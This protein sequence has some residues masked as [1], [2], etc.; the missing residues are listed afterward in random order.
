MIKVGRLLPFH[1]EG[2]KEVCVGVFETYTV[3]AYEWEVK[4]SWQAAV[5]KKKSIEWANNLAGSLQQ[6]FSGIGYLSSLILKGLTLTTSTPPYLT[7]RMHIMPRITQNFK[8][9][10]NN[11]TPRIS[12]LFHNRY[13]YNRMPS[14]PSH[15]ELRR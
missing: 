3:L 2:T 5:D 14:R 7:G 8:K 4:A 6:H 11:T 1:T 13:H 10:R 12:S 9:L 15:E